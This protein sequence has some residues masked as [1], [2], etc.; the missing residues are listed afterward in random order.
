METTTTIK[1]ATI[2]GRSF[3]FVQSQNPHYNSV[4]IISAIIIAETGSDM[5][6]FENSG[7][8]TGRAECTQEMTKLP[9]N[10]NL[11]SLPKAITI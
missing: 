11:S 7:K 4:I 8:P 2:C 9:A 10:T 5:K 6:T 3:F 1:R